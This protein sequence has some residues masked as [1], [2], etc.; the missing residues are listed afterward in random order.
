M[1]PIY[2]ETPFLPLPKRFAAVT[3]GIFVFIRK[4]Q[5]TETRKKHEETHVFQFLECAVVGLMLA[6]VAHIAGIVSPVVGGILGVSLFYILYLGEFAYRLVEWKDAYNAYRDISFEREA[7]HQANR[8]ADRDWFA[9][10]E[11]L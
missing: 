5:A 1:K 3:I 6:T 8:M 11:Y 7:R 4:G 9:W 10:V 2:I